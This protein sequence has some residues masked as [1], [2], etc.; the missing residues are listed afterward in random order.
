[1]EAVAAGLEIVT[2]VHQ[3]R[4]PLTACIWPACGHKQR[5]HR[6]VH[7]LVVGDA[8]CKQVKAGAARARR[9]R[10][11]TAAVVGVTCC[12][13]ALPALDGATFEVVVLDE[14]S[15]MIEPLSL[16]PLVRASCRWAT[17]Q[18]MAMEVL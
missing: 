12:S 3:L 6:E 16:L 1:M 5:F 15:Q 18:S 13:A 4:M 11:T 8:T 7:L 17:S 14:A 2:V 9:Q 10:L